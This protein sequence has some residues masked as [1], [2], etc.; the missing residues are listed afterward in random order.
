M[1]SLNSNPRLNKKKIPT[2]GQPS[3]ETQGKLLGHKR[4]DVPSV[5]ISSVDFD[6]P[7][8]RP[9]RSVL[10]SPELSI[11]TVASS[12]N[13]VISSRRPSIVIASPSATSARLHFS[14]SSSLS[15]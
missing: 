7:D 10:S 5:E 8:P 4:K 9:D 13:D 6:I 11:L 14:I 1:L 3:P 12:N 15:H 2:T